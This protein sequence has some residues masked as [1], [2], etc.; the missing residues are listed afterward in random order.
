MTLFGHYIFA[1]DLSLYTIAPGVFGIDEMVSD[2][3]LL[4]V[5]ALPEVRILRRHLCGCSQT[6]TA[7]EKE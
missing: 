5:Y 7:G 6:E 3:G 2:V 4:R 1:F